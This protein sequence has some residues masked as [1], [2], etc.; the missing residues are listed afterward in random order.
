MTGRIVAGDLVLPGGGAAEVP[1]GAVL[2]ADGLV[3]DV[4]PY[5]E[6]VERAAPGTPVARYP[7]STILPGLIDSHVHLVFDASADPV[8]AL[9]GVDDLDLLAAMAARAR[10]LLDS[11]VTTV[12][13]LGDRGGLARR[14]RDTI[15]A[16]LLPGPR[17][18]AA[19]TPLTIPGGHCWFLGGEV[20]DR[21]ELLATTRAH[22]ASGADV[23]KVMAT[24]GNLTPG[25][26]QAWQG[27]FDADSIAA[28]V[29]EAHAAGLRV[30]AHA[31]G[32]VGVRAALA[33]G[34]DTLEHCTFIPEAGPA[35][36]PDVRLDLVREIADRGVFVCPTFS[37]AFDLTEARIGR[38]AMGPWLDVARVLHEHGVTLIA[39]TD[40]GIAGAR[41]DAYVTGLE[42]LARAGL[43]NTDV[44]EMAGANAAAALGLG[45]VTGRLAPGLAADLVV[46]TGDP[47]ADLA[48]LRKVRL[49]LA[50]G[51][52]HLPPAEIEARLG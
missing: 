12:R 17:V 11:G 51:R 43:A 6:V 39:G 33:A 47:R 1:H 49:V 38:P 18:L 29:R 16:G 36:G 7:G 10:Q 50:G 3:R 4:G 45:D 23:L 22:I 14:L 40:A 13:D 20:A 28:V 2:V 30:A 32:A 41:F 25:G 37:R 31:H 27:Q 21:D 8:A 9:D 15:A 44:L 26:P 42:W 5:A 35:A 24:G 19:N 34:A 52:P 48:A 46:V